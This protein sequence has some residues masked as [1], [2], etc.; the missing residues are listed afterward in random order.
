MSLRK[1]LGAAVPHVHEQV[2]SL[3]DGEDAMLISAALDPG[4]LA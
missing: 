1:S 3:L 2:E 4:R